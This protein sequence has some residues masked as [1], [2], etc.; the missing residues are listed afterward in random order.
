VVAVS[1]KNVSVSAD[2][3]LYFPRYILPIMPVLAVLG[4]R[5]LAD[6][7]EKL[8]AGREGVVGAVLVALLCVIPAR[9]IALANHLMV[10]PDTR[11]LAKDWMHAN[12]PA[13]S[14]VFIE[15]LRVRVYPATV[16]LENSKE[17][18]REGIKYFLKDEPGKAKYFQMKL[19]VLSGITYDLVVV[20][21]FRL[22]DLQSYL[23]KGVEYFVLRPDNYAGSRLQN[24][25]ADFV[26]QVESHPD[27]S[28]IQDFVPDPRS[29]PGSRI[30]I[31]GVGKE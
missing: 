4:G 10:Q 8:A 5:V 6:G 9:E 13:G 14:K 11:V 24:D 28:L 20:Q 2:T 30:A 1:L 22:E 3:H 19:K 31:Y 18:L 7:L 17:N 29:T 16:P 15:G 25:W 21:T 23:D 27:V 12:V 26:D